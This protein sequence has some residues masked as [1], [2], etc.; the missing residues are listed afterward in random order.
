V[1]LWVCSE[2]FLISEATTEKPFPAS[3]AL[4]ASIEAF[5]ASKLVCFVML[6]ISDILC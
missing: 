3:P 1:K 2:S 5:S 4:A 6:F